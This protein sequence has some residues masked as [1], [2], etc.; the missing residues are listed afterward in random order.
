M[1]GLSQDSVLL[2][3]NVGVWLTD[4]TVSQKFRDMN[5]GFLMEL[6]TGRYLMAAFTACCSAGTL[7]GLYGY[8][9]NE[10]KWQNIA[11]PVH[12]KNVV[13]LL[14]RGD[15]LMVMLRSGILLTTIANFF[16]QTAIPEAG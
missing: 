6:T 13:D 2:Y 4:S 11:L 9:Q 5:A 8:S 14:V 12:E 1:Y 7:F 15:G 10:Q 16:C 3:G